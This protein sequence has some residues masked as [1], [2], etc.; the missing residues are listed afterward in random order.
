MCFWWYNPYYSPKSCSPKAMREQRL[1]SLKVRRDALETK[2]AAIN[3]A[4]ESMEQQI[5]R[6]EGPTA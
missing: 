1:K 3:A 4:I 2:L 5:N 6:E